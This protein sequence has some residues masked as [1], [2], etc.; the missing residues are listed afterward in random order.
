[1]V[2]F[3]ITLPKEDALQLQGRIVE[4]VCKTQII[5]PT[6]GKMT[7]WRGS[8]E[9]EYFSIM[10][11]CGILVVSVV[12]RE[13]QLGDISVSYAESESLTK[14]INTINGADDATV[15]KIREEYNQ[16]TSKKEQDEITF[17]DVMLTLNWRYAPLAKVD[18]DWLCD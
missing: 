13:M 9:N 6:F 11:I 16:N 14:A 10:F 3:Q 5:N 2:N 8:L 18:E 12:E 17:D 1:M 15:E 7:T 4:Y